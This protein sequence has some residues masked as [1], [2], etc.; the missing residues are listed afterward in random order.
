VDLGIDGLAPFQTDDADFYR[1]D[2]ELS[3]PQIDPAGWSLRI[4]GM[5]DEE[6]TYTYEELL[7]RDDLVEADIT[8]TCVSNEVG[9]SL[10][11]SGRWTGVP[12]QNLL[13]EV[14]VQ[15]G[16]DQLVGR[17]GRG[18]T[19]GF[20]VEVLD[21]G[22]TALLAL[23]LNGEP[24]S[25]ERGF[26][27]RTIVPGLYGYVSATKWIEEIEL[28]TF[29]GF[30]QYWVE[31]GWEPVAPIKL[32]SRIDVPRPLQRIP[33]GQEI[34]VAGVAWHQT[35]GIEQVEIRV[36]D[37]EWQPVELA[38]E[39]NL[40]TWR[41]WRFPWTP[42]EPGNYRLTVRATNKAGEVQTEERQP[43][44]PDGATGY[45]TLLVTVTEDA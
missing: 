33:A 18:F 11:S 28:T 4:H 19:T 40:D 5:V 41:Q 24:L 23:L 10:M 34:A 12:L 22:R 26:P 2:I 42:A 35:V 37:G 15:P 21:D 1:I 31:R 39:L 6:R 44:F 43:P 30:D 7:R 8:L 17:D 20:P 29:A 25:P 14:G 16:A 36:D 3:V 38:E 13:A 9:G 45:M 32:Q 27:A